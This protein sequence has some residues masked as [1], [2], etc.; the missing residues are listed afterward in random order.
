MGQ[1]TSQQCHLTRYTKRVVWCPQDT[2]CTAWLS[3]DRMAMAYTHDEYCDMLLTLGACNS[4]AG[5]AAR[6]Y[7]LRC[8]GIRYVVQTLICFDDWSSVSVRQEVQN[9]RH[10]L[11]QVD[12]GLYGQ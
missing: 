6:E 12:H 1:H 10:L 5:T 4:P 3:C 2:Q 8:L 11:M 9:Q 7:G